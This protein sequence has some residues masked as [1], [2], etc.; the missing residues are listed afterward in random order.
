MC[1]VYHAEADLSKFPTDFANQ[2]DFNALQNDRLGPCLQYQY[3]A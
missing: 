1:H 2:G 3:A